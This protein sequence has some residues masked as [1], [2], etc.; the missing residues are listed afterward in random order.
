VNVITTRIND[1]A[2]SNL[3]WSHIKQ[4][5]RKLNVKWKDFSKIHG[6]PNSHGLNLY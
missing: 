6:Q 5:K 1:L 3:F 2:I 4:R